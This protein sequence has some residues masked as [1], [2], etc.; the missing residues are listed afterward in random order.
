VAKAGGEV[1]LQNCDNPVEEHMQLGVDVGVE[2]TPA[3]ILDTGEMIPGYLPPK[4]LL[5]RLGMAKP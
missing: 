5:S 2:G 4:Q 1:E 3:I